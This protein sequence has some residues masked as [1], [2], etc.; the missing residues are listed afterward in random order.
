MSSFYTGGYS[1]YQR[2]APKFSHTLK[3]KKLFLSLLYPDKITFNTHTKKIHKP[4]QWNGLSGRVRPEYRHQ[5]CPAVS[6]VLQL[7]T[8]PPLESI[9]ECA[10]LVKMGGLQSTI[11][12]LNVLLRRQCD[13]L[14]PELC[15][16]KVGGGVVVVVVFK[17]EE[18]KLFWRVFENFKA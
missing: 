13:R 11:L 3:K 9:L 7:L 4:L 17:S 1:K 16:C 8:M 2:R 6:S 10:G 12:S 15:L 5:R 14:Q 18:V